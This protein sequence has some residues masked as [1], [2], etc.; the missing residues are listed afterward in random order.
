MITLDTIF[1][2]RDNLDTLNSQAAFAIMMMFIMHPSI[3]GTVKRW[4]DASQDF[5]ADNV[6]HVMM[7][8]EHGYHSYDGH[9]ASYI[10]KLIEAYQL[11]QVKRMHELRKLLGVEIKVKVHDKRELLE[12]LHDYQIGEIDVSEVTNF[13]G[14]FFGEKRNDWYQLVLWSPYMQVFTPDL[15]GFKPELNLASMF[16]ESNIDDSANF[17]GWFDKVGLALTCTY[18]KLIK[19]PH[20]KESRV[21]VYESKYDG[22]T[23]FYRYYGCAKPSKFQYKEYDYDRN[24]KFKVDGH[25]YEC[26]VD[27]Y[28]VTTKFKTDYMFADCKLFTGVHTGMENW[29]LAVLKSGAH[30]FDGCRNLRADVSKWCVSM[31]TNFINMFKNCAYFNS[32]LTTWYIPAYLALAVVESKK[33]H[34]AVN[35]YGMFENCRKFNQSVKGLPFSAHTNCSYMFWGC[36]SFT[37]LG[38]PQGT[39]DNG[40]HYDELVRDTLETTFENTQYDPL[41]RLI[42]VRTT[43]AHYPTV[44]IGG[45]PEHV[46]VKFEQA[47][48]GM[49]VSE[50]NPWREANGRTAFPEIPLVDSKF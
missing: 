28:D 50:F 22:A 38:L 1:G 13:N 3:V 36:L 42:E 45:T 27:Y 5:D 47:L 48:L 34:N 4:F 19:Y 11:I 14:V 9:D 23:A 26:L 8:L 17:N 7:C 18:L 15:R 21:Q 30:M 24:I 33:E 29:C 6:A 10:T 20:K 32:P 25:R 43:L 12:A 31:C 37:G 41:K 16:M 39:K 44:G 40:V 2:S 46:L 49:L 35:Y